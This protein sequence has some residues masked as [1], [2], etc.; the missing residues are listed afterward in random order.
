M[1]DSPELLVAICVYNEMDNL[2]WLYEQLR[3]LPL[4]ASIVVV[5]DNSPDGTGKWCDETAAKDDHFFVIHR[6]GKLG[7]GS[8]SLAAF[9][10]AIK[11]E[12]R[13]VLMMDGDRSHSPSEVPDVYGKLLED[14]ENQIA[15]GSRYVSGG[16]I[17]NWPLMRHVMSRCINAFSRVMIGLP[18]SDYSSAFRCYRVELLRRIDL[19]QISATGYAYLEELL[20][21]AGKH[22]ARIVEQ[23]I[24]FV[25]RV[26]GSSKINHKEAIRAVWVVFRI[27]LS[28][29]F[30]KNR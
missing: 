25:D 15:I 6:E 12:F 29:V 14:P 11:S 9:R 5:D 13:Y 26:Q 7:L 2:P 28:R 24:V 23:P 21:H 4:E 10:Y 18:I 8:A 3:A 22:G 30:G 17:E 19:N 16:R 27:G 20:W 1:P